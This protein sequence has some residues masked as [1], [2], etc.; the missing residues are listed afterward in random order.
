M[1]GLGRGRGV[2]TMEDGWRGCVRVFGGCLGSYEAGTSQ[3]GV[4]RFDGE[5]GK[6][7]RGNFAEQDGFHGV[8]PHVR[9]GEGVGV[10]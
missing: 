2:G 10:E 9:V 4:V 6:Q 7:T 5:S 8:L 3:E 1:F